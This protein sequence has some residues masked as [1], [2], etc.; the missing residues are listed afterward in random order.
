MGRP[1]SLEMTLDDRFPINYL[2]TLVW[3]V[4]LKKFRFLAWR[5]FTGSIIIATIQLSSKISPPT[6][7]STPFVHCPL[8][9]CICSD[10][11]W[12]VPSFVRIS[13]PSGQLA[14]TIVKAPYSRLTS[15]LSMTA[16]SA[17][18][19]SVHVSENNY[20]NLFF[21]LFSRCL[22]FILLVSNPHYEL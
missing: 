15:W 3:S 22:P 19:F 7:A 18:G 1:L 13:I 16:V 11:P 10:E 5:F 2:A 6:H 9:H 21:N 17:S 8:L 4:E 14:S 12:T 20:V